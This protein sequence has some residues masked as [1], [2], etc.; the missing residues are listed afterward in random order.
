MGESRTKNTIRNTLYSFI[1][2]LTDVFLAFFLRT[3]FIKAL[4]MSYLGLSGLFTN[5]LTVL[6]LMEL[7]V[8][9]AIIFSLY[10]PIAEKDNAKIVSL[11][12]LYRQI[13]NCVGVVITVVGLLLTPFLKYIINLPDNIHGIYVIYWLTIANTGVT[14]FLSYR[15]SLLMAD[16]RSDINSRNLIMFRI[17]RCIV[18]SIALITFRNY[19]IYLALDILTTLISNIHITFV[20]KKRY[21]YL[22]EVKASPLSKEEKNNILKYM[23]SGIFSK[24]GQTVVTSTDNILIS[25][26]IS[27]V[28]VGIY[29]NYSMITNNLEVF[30]YLLFNGVTASIGNYAVTKKSGDAEQLFRKLNFVNFSIAFVLTVCLVSLMSPFV[31][32]WAGKE[33][34]LSFWTVIVICVNFY[35]AILQKSVENFM[36]AVGKM[37]YINR[38]RSLIEGGVNLFVSICLVRFTNLGITGVFL[39]TTV[40]FLCGRVWMDAH[41][42]YKYWFNIPTSKYFKRYIFQFGLTVIVSVLGY[43]ISNIIFGNFGINILTWILSGCILVLITCSIL[44]LLYR[45]SEEYNYFLTLI[46]NRYK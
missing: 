11:M 15:R 42:L 19:I 29:S 38:Y 31:S 33:Y 16:Q 41:T 45:H 22:S 17:I 39:G 9:S 18:L 7:G 12:R 6:S 43:I 27:T 20:I 5:I 28:L 4:G 26:F 40:C 36:S 24:V 35:I 25:A 34:T 21:S 44:L 3:L 23:T 14:Y 37:F 1:Y 10:K 2:K 32:I 30:V 8:G 46:K 13:Y